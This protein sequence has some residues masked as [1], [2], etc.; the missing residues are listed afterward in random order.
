M[1]D[2]HVETRTGTA[3]LQCI[4]D[5]EEATDGDDVTP[6]TE[7]NIDLFKIMYKGRNIMRLLSINSI[8][9]IIAEIKQD[10]EDSLYDASGQVF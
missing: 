2:Y 8:E 5:Y 1:F 7:T 9:A 6:S 3:T 10:V 4:Y